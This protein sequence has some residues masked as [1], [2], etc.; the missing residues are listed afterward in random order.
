ME[1][2]VFTGGGVAS[3][4]AQMIVVEER[5]AESRDRFR[6]GGGHRAMG[7]SAS[8]FPLPESLACRQ[9]AMN[10]AHLDDGEA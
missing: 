8:R 3:R 4:S 7:H 2:C 5:F 6:R 9:L 10:D 1:F